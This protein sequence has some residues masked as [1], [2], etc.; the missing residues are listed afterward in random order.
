MD[1]PK[2]YWWSVAIVVPIVIAVIGII[3]KFVS[4]GDAK[5][6]SFHVDVVGTQFNGEVAFN[7]VTIVAEQARQELGR[8]LPI[9]VVEA[10]RKALDLAKAQNFDEAIPAFEAVAK[11][12]PVPAVLNN[13]GAAYLAT[14]NKVKATRYLEEALAM[15]TNEKS[16]QFNLEQAQTE[17]QAV[18]S[19][20]EIT[21]ASD[22]KEQPAARDED[23]KPNDTI[24]QASPLEVDTELNAEISDPKD[25][26]FYKFQYKASLRD[27]LTVKME[28]R[29]TTLRPHVKVYDKNK[30][31]IL[32]HYNITYG[33]SLEFAMSVEPQLDYYLH[34]HPYDGS[35]QYSLTV[36]S[37]QAYD[38]HEPNDD[39][40]TATRMEVGQPITANIMDAKDTDWYQLAGVKSEAVTLKMEI[41]SAT[42]RPHVK[43]Y[44]KNKSQIANNYNIT[45]GASL[46]FAFKA[47][48]G[49][50][51]Y[52]QVHP[53]DGYGNY[54]LSAQ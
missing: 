52:L 27:R 23:Q 40:F 45:Y 49:A 26:D 16:A 3:P 33:A 11:A 32:N 41:Q 21:T 24:F 19:A 28:S 7:N 20:T 36:V 12:V 34:V 8:E 25:Q 46:E 5:A 38:R 9:D 47:E 37:H 31:L 44:D 29:A 39:Q 35:G 18:D 50:D 42:L 51:Y 48:P 43:V 30:A 10:L 4:D 14:G 15:T 22:T 2:K 54:Q 13:L 6:E 53:Y 1:I 17:N